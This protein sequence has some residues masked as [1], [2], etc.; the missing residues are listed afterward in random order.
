M[1]NLK[2]KLGKPVELSL[3]EKVMMQEVNQR[4]LTASTK[5]AELLRDL[6]LKTSLSVKTDQ[7]QKLMEIDEITSK[8]GELFTEDQI[9][10]LALTYNLRFLSI[11]NYSREVPQIL[12]TELLKVAEEFKF[13]G[14]NNKHNLER[15]TFVL[16]PASH[17]NLV[18]GEIVIDLHL[19]D[20][21]PAVFVQVKSGL[22]KLVH[23]W[24]SDLNLLNMIAGIVK[25]TDDS[26][27]LSWFIPMLIL[28]LPIVL[29]D[30]FWLYCITAIISLIASFAIASNTY[31]NSEIWNKDQSSKSTIKVLWPWS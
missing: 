22:Y 1:S 3:M 27:F 19:P 21:D 6:G 17:F 26:I 12:G 24:G 4:L 9:K 16:A 14:Y 10:N 7:V 18:K 11:S 28:T 30:G 20:S 13:V 23:S 31:S 2:E 29:I 15:I 25:K 5:E 8:H